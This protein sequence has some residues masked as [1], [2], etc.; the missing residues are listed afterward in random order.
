MTW[1]DFITTRKKSRK[2]KSTPSKADFHPQGQEDNEMAYSAEITAE[3]ESHPTLGA[4]YFAAREVAERFLKNW[5]QDHA[6]K[7]AE[8]IMRP[9]LDAVQEKVWDAFKDFLLSDTEQNVQSE[10]RHMVENS[11]RALIGGDKWANVKYIE[12]SYGD[13][14]KVRETLA[15]L[16][17]DEIKDGRI[18]DLESEVQRLKDNL[19]FHENRY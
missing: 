15:Q 18:R 8:A 13:G 19:R 10:M 6:E 4:E 12:T 7:L 2:S 17:R 16:Y 14:K 5:Q 3:A 11:V 9:V 1:C